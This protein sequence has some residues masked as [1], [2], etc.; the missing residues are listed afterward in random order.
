MPNILTD[1][2][3]D[4]NSPSGLTWV[5][6]YHKSKAGKSVG[7][8]DKNTGRWILNF[9]GKIYKVHR[10]VWELKNGSLPKGYIVDHIDGNPTNNLI[11][12]LRLATSSQ[13]AVNSASSKRELPRCVFK[14]KDSGYDVKV[15]AGGVVYYSHFISLDEAIAW[16]DY[17]REAKQGAFISNRLVGA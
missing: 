14:H 4:P 5:N 12:N 13:N 3:Y 6:P 1:V 17:I 16:R 8:L 15:G 11:A 10:I 7:Y 2:V 9:K